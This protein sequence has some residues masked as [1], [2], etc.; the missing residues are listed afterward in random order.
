VLKIGYTER[1]VE[2]RVKE[3]NGATGIVE[4]YGVRA[5]WIVLKAPLVEKAVHDA[6]A[7][8]R[9][10]GGREFSNSVTRQPS[11]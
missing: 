11:E 6:L 7:E 1:A 10:R 9:V 3:I 4:P 8:Y 2:Q 5:V